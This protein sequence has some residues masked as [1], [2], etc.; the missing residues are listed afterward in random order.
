M[1]PL[2]TLHFTS[3]E[4]TMEW[5]KAHQREL[6]PA[7]LTR[8]TADT[9]TGGRGQFGRTWH[10]PPG[11]LYASFCFFVPPGWPDLPHAAQVLALSAATVLERYHLK[12]TLKWPNDLLIEGKKVGGVLAEVHHT[13]V[14]DGIGINVSLTEEECARIDQPATSLSLLCQPTPRVE[15]VCD[16]ITH[17]FQRDLER[18]LKEGFA[19]FRDPFE[20]H[21]NSRG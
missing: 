4:S 2:K 18:F 10:S 1:L 19:P 14:V 13:L 5:A 15:E 12:P 9:Q 16:A 6:D 11:N 20:K 7:A 21:L 3:L 8:I 17:T